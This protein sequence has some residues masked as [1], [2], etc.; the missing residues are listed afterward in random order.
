[1]QPKPVHEKTS[2]APNG[3]DGEESASGDTPSSLFPPEASNQFKVK[4]M[5][6][7]NAASLSV[8][9]PETFARQ[10]LSGEV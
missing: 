1:M 2:Y 9:L 10:R 6:P 8:K 3:N 7:P 5:P 4:L